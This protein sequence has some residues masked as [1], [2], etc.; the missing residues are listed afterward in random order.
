MTTATEFQAKVTKAAVN[1]DRLDGIVNGA[2]NFD[3][4]TDAGPVPS[5]AKLA[6]NFRGW[7]PLLAIHTDGARSVLTV[8]D[9]VGGPPGTT[10]PPIGSYVGPDGL[11]SVLAEAVNIRGSAGA[12]GQSFTVD[13][14]GTLVER[15]L[16]DAEEPPFAYIATDV[17]GGTLYFRLGPAGEWTDGVPFGKGDP[18]K[19]VEI[20]KSATHIQWRYA[21]DSSWINLV[22]L[23]DIKGADGSAATITQSA[24]ITALG[25]TPLNSGA[26]AGAGGA[27]QVGHSSSLTNEVTLPL[28]HYVKMS[29][30]T[31]ER[32]GY[33]GSNSTTDDQAVTRWFAALQ[34]GYVGRLDSRVYNFTTPL[35][36][37]ASNIAIEGRDY[38][39]VLMYNGASSTSDVITIGNQSY[40]SINWV[41][42]GFRIDSNTTMSGGCGI[43]AYNFCRSR[44]NDVTLGGQDGNEKLFDLVWLDGMDYVYIHG[45]DYHGRGTGIR[46]NSARNNTSAAAAGLFLHHGKIGGMGGWGMHF[47]GGLGG[48]YIDDLDIIACGLL[49]T[50]GGVKI[51]NAMV[52]VQN[53]E[54]MFGKGCSIDGNYG[55]G[56]L[57]NDSLIGTGWCTFVGTWN[58]SNTLDALFVQN[59]GYA[60]VQVVGGTYYKNNRDGIR[61]NSGLPT[62]LQ[63]VGPD[64]RNNGR[65]GINAPAGVS[66]C[67]PWFANNL[68]G[69]ITGGVTWRS[70][71]ARDGTRYSTFSGNNPLE[72]YDSN[73]YMVFNRGTSEWEFYIGG[74]RRGRIT[75]SGFVNS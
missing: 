21:G 52:G 9:W 35:S 61:M 66:A 13:Q 24:I 12:D 31:P 62:V 18:G 29:G 59:F 44:L 23:S 42:E 53:R 47:G 32:F 48:V 60:T 56:V 51:D 57:L 7:S 19:Q 14:V 8:A 2:D 67:E 28:T 43:H 1:M 33:T 39:S 27:A 11:T 41:L 54:F 25:F 6:K 5:L 20:Q 71:T 73:D 37:A 58:C 3:Q 55:Y 36:K 64:V 38:Q 69:D 26:L 68:G 22:A 15:D 50:S 46:A 70:G 34:S 40:N 49:G 45:M 4:G 30:L 65:Y 16:Y 74:V 63:I 17:D 75:A 72:A 10:K